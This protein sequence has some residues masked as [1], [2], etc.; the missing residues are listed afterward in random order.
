VFLKTQ[1]NIFYVR[2]KT[3]PTCTGLL[4]VLREK[5][6]FQYSEWTLR[7]Y[8]RVGLQM[9]EMYQNGNFNRKSAQY[10]L[11]MQ[12]FAVLEK[13]PDKLPT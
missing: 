5:I 6:H 13:L 8:K 10:I 7:K 1:L 11:E 3:A 12:V 4:T 9:E 2:Q